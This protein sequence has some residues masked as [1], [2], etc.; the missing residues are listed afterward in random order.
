VNAP[1]LNDRFP[2]RLAVFI[3]ICACL[4][5]VVAGCGDDPEAPQSK[6]TLV[7]TMAPDTLQSSWTLTDPGG[8]QMRG[9][10]PDTLGNL[11]TGTYFVFWD[12]V[13]GWLDP[14]PNPSVGDVVA[15]ETT[16]ITGEYRDVLPIWDTFVTI[17]AG[18]FMMG[19]PET[20]PG[21]E[22]D[23]CSEYPQHEVTLT[24]SFQ[25]QATE[26]TNSQFVDLANWA[27][28]QGYAQ[29]DETSLWTS[30]DG[31]ATKLMDFSCVI[32]C[33][34]EFVGGKLRLV[35]GGAGVNPDNPA[36]NMTWFGAAAYCD[37]LSLKE[38]LTRAY[39]HSDWSCNGGDPYGAAGYRLPT[40]AEWEYACRAG[41]TT[42]FA[43]GDI[44]DPYG[45]YD[46]V[47]EEIG[48]YRGNSGSWSHPVAQLIPNG[49]GL[50]DMH[51]SVL[52]W[53]QGYWYKFSADP[54]TDPLGGNR[55]LNFVVR[56]GAW[57][58][59]PYFSRSAFRLPQGTDGS[60]LDYFGPKQG[61]R[62]ARTQP[63]G[64]GSHR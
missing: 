53:V 45:D 33:E 55:P 25:M 60:G 5:V 64:S 19:A 13:E 62:P 26:V 22:C 21:S 54:V 63:P 49:W 28:G 46:P 18:T 43:N 27:L 16:T 50:Y 31:A 48:W 37:W 2:T 11:T 24:R 10:G 23:L 42:A 17:P 1:A 9:T 8:Y 39:D 41:T 12:A 40:E 6:G 56:S 30:L 4:M 47:L 38:G 44:T 52:E 58:R 14:I 20:E 35:D 59:P 7:V 15:N 57:S 3:G 32:I 51:G 36:G 29:G 61:F 34:I